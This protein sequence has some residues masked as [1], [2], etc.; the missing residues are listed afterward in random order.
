MVWQVQQLTCNGAL[1]SQRQGLGLSLTP[2][3][4]LSLVHRDRGVFLHHGMPSI[5]QVL[6]SWAQAEVSDDGSVS[7][8]TMQDIIV[9]RRMF[10]SSLSGGQ[11]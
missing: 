11:D 2:P 3:S 6:K 8:K 9:I 5:P 10:M 1:K 7:T 4:L